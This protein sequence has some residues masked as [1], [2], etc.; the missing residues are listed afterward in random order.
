MT[1]TSRGAEQTVAALRRMTVGQ[2][3]EKYLELFGEPTRSENRNFLFKR[4]AW[5]VQSMA[6]GTL[7]D[8]AR[9]RADELARDADFRTTLP[10]P[11]K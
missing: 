7:S 9:R 6:E 1:A 11:P 4:L 5:R 10:R 3:R 8:R 2:L